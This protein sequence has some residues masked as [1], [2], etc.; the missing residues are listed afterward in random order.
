MDISKATTQ[1][2]DGCR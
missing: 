1:F 2:V